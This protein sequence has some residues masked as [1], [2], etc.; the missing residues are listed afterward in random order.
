MFTADLDVPPSQA[1][2]KL[3]TLDGKRS[4]KPTQQVVAVELHIAKNQLVLTLVQQV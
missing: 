2:V 4:T 1:A 3:K